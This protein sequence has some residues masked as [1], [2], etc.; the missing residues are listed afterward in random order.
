MIY[1]E[2]TI[3]ISVVDLKQI[4]RY[5]SSK[6]GPFG[7]NKELQFWTRGLMA[8]HRANTENKDDEH[9]FI[10]EKVNSEVLL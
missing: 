6:M 4:A 5:F 10:E 8:N 3:N 9:S 1:N 7:N 2:Y